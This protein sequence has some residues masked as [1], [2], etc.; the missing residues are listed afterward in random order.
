MS[1]LNTYY[2]LNLED[3]KIHDKI[4]LL[5]TYQFSNINFSKNFIHSLQSYDYQ[6]TI[7]IYTYIEKNFIEIH[8]LL[9]KRNER[10]F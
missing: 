1:N 8:I 4:S 7:R 5:S 6:F 3:I 9:L 2:Y 10:N